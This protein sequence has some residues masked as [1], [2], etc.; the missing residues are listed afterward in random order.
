MKL[1]ESYSRSTSVD[2][3]HKPFLY[4]KYFPLPP[5]I[6]KYITLQNSSGMS[7]KNY[8]YWQEVVDILFPI[9]EKNGIKILLLG[10]KDSTPLNKVIN[11][12]GQTT[13]HQSAYLVK[14]ALLHFGNDSWLCHYAGAEDVPLVSLYGSTT[15]ANHSP[16]FFN[17]DKTIFL[18]SDRNGQK[19]SFAREENPKTIDLIKSEL[20][21]ESVC[22]LL[23]LE[24][25]YPYKTLVTGRTYFSK[26]VESACDNVVNVQALNIPT[27]IIRYDY[28]QN[29]AILTQQLQL[30][31]C[32]IVTDRPIPINILIQLKS[33][34]IEICYRIDK[35]HNP[36]FCQELQD[37]KFNYRLYSELTEEELNKIKLDYIDFNIIVRREFKKPEVLEKYKIEDIYYRGAKITIGKGK[38]YSSKWAYLN[39][40]PQISFDI[41]PQSLKDKN[42]QELW[43]EEEY[44]IFLEKIDNNSKVE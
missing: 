31:K 4:Q 22:K 38:I 15:V 8:T 30:G 5:E 28:N 27:I 10:D 39:D 35:N 26:M 41:Q 2:I 20:V 11:L 9:L 7:A 24:Y 36:K 44:M 40:L 3:K 18:E 13:I 12:C 43:M 1:L 14:R 23:G 17:K 32:S 42:L 19:A 21:A 16:Y 37:N 6:T 33:N 29:L 34:I 25:T